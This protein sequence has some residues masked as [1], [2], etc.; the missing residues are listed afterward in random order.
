MGVEAMGV[1]MMTQTGIRCAVVLVLL[2]LALGV[3]AAEAL[4]RVT[5][6]ANS[7]RPE[8][9][10]CF[11][12]SMDFGEEGDKATSNQSQLQVFEDGK[13]L[14]PG[15]SLHQ[16]IREQ[17]GGRFSHWTREGLYFSASDNSD[18]RTNGRKYE[19]AS[20]NPMSSLGGLARFPVTPHSHV[21][22]I[23][24][25]R[26]EYAISMGGTLH[27][28]NTTT[29]AC[30]NYQVVFQPNIQLTLENVGDTP[31]VN[32]R[33]VINDRG[34]W[35]TFD[36]LLEEFTRGATTDQ[37]RVYSIWQNM[38]QNLYHSSPL[39][40]NNEPH[41]PVKLFNVYGLNLCDDA[42][43]A[44][45]SLFIHSGFKGSQNRALHGHVQCE[46]FIDGGLQFMDVDMDAFYLDYENE[47]PVS[48]DAVARDHH[49]ARRELNYGPVVDRWTN[50]EGPAALFGPDDGAAY[51]D[52]RGHEI[53]YTLRPGERAEFR[54]DNIGKFNAESS[55]WAHKPLYFGNSKVVYE[56]KLT[57]ERMAADALASVDVGDATADGASVAG[58]SADA[59][60]IY[61][62]KLAYPAC[63]GA[64]RADF[65]GL[66][67]ADRFSL[68]LSFDGET[69]RPLWEQQGKGAI[70][71]EL[72]LDEALDVQN[73]PAKYLY[74]LKVG[75]GSATAAHGANLA[76]L[77]I[78][79]DVMAAPVSL[80]RL[81][82]GDNRVLYT[83]ATQ[84]PHQLRITHEWQECDA[85]TPLPPPAMP[86]SPADGAAVA[87][88]L[89]EYSWPAVDGAARYHLQVSRR[90]D[91]RFPYRPGLD[92]IIPTTT[93]AVPHTGIYSPDQTYYW[94]VR[95][96][97][98]YGV[99]G[100]WSEPWHFTW[101]GPRVPVNV[102]LEQTGQTF[103]LRW[104]PNPRGPRP[105]RYEVYG[106]DEKGFPIKKESY[107]NWNL[108]EMPP[109]FL[110]DTVET[111]MLVIDHGAEHPA[112]NRVYYRVVAID[113]AGTPGGPSDYAEAPHPFIYS[114]P[115][116]GATAGRE[117]R[118]QV[119]SL[120]SV[121][122]LQ[123]HYEKPYDQFWDV[124]RNTYALVAGPKWL[125]LDAQTGL[126]SGTPAAGDRGK[127]AVR[128]EVSNQ[129]EGKVG[130]EFELQVE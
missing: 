33:L 55:E 81:R 3:G 63:G 66:D 15:K 1:A 85:V 116:T 119:R 32:P 26:H 20:A 117:Y 31:V 67:A 79:T 2:L 24:S 61:E 54:W 46:A 14:G 73:K 76:S 56:P 34:N 40:A 90:E 84:G 93:W 113:A 74:Y 95:S 11:I 7:I 105:V 5:I 52:L 77:R 96:R 106:S 59:A 99:W 29:V 120:T 50:S 37:E 17:G 128:I 62:M 83:D 101:V 36:S 98:R 111:S 127:A 108:G 18:P 70:T 45:C 48:G 112:M 47:R 44:G 19:V 53:A 89:V 115:V 43:N 104:D 69:W 94:R 68:T 35:Y 102:R 72:S 64:I 6:P 51:P 58:L 122:D 121:G 39:F 30:S 71:A 21:E 124:E 129:F 125:T 118:Y 86:T 25:A 100:E 57:R 97:D 23:A 92:V 110:A 16:A 130:Q 10:F 41:D 13:P 75:L 22:E 103:T 9:G 65:V 80:P 126:L 12:A 4:L 78:A 109:N 88:G 42:G 87:A 82:L 60:L 91:F 28:E 8:N 27:M 49:L 123:H 114:E 107:N 38:R